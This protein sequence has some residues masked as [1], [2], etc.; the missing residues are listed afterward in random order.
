M[1]VTFIFYFCS[2]VTSLERHLTFSETPFL[3]DF[4]LSAY[5]HL[6]Y[7]LFLFLVHQLECKIHQNREFFSGFVFVLLFSAG[8][9]EFRT[10]FDINTW[11]VNVE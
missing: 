8:S 7:I 3:V 6:V 2:S 10:V 9:P 5:L 1:A 11:S 4:F